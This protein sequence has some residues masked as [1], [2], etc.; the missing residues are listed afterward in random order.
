MPGGAVPCGAGGLG[1]VVAGE[2]KRCAR[3]G[4]GS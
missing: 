3:A 4:D 1:R 2:A